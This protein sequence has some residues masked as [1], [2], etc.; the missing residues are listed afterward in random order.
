MPTAIKDGEGGVIDNCNFVTVQIHSRQTVVGNNFSVTRF[1]V[2][3]ATDSGAHLLFDL[4]HVWCR[5]VDFYTIHEMGEGTT[6][7]VPLCSLVSEHS[8][9]GIAH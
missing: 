4:T 2:L 8:E 7:A 1:P 6:D 3:V 9:V 5:L